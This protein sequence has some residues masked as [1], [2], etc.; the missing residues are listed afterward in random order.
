MDHAQLLSAFRE[1]GIL[2]LKEGNGKVITFMKTELWKPEMGEDWTFLLFDLFQIRTICE[3]FSEVSLDIVEYANKPTVYHSPANRIIKNG[4]I[5][6]GVLKFSLILEPNWNKLLFQIS[7][8]VVVKIDTNETTSHQ[9]PILFPLLSPSTKEM[10]L[11]PDG[12]V[13]ILK[14]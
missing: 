1:K 2:H 6:D 4:P 8:P 7:Q 11:G 3:P 12:D 14:G 10:F 5:V 9:T 13:K